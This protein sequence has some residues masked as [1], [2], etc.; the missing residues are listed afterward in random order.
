MSRR[1][2]E[3][4]R[5]LPLD[6]GLV[7]SLRSPKRHGKHRERL[8]AET[9]TRPAALAAAASISWS[10]SWA[11]RAGRSGGDRFAALAKVAGLPVI[12]STTHDIYMRDTDA[13]SWSPHGCDLQVARTRHGQ[14]HDGHLRPLPRRCSGSSGGDIGVPTGALRAVCEIAVKFRSIKGLGWG[15]P[16]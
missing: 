1:P 14:L 11:A 15:E 8:E 5:T 6:E 16:I 7:A 4:R 3:G 13:P 12:G 10:M 9:P 2:S